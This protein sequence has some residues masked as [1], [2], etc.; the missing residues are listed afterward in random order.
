MPNTFYKTFWTGFLGEIRPIL[1]IEVTTAIN[2]DCVFG[3]TAQYEVDAPC[4]APIIDD[5]QFGMGTLGSVEFT[6]PGQNPCVSA[7]IEWS[8]DLISWFSQSLGC[9]SPSLVDIGSGNNY[10]SLY[11]RIQKTCQDGGL[12]SPYSELYEYIFPTPNPTPTNTPTSTNTP[13][14]TG[15]MVSPTPTPT[16]TTTPTETPT[17]TPTETPT[18]TPTTT[19]TPTNTPTPTSSPVPSTAF[20]MTIKTDNP[21]ATNT[22]TFRLPTRGT[23]NNFTIDWGDGVI[24]TFTGNTGNKDHIYSTA[25]TYQLSISATTLTGLGFGGTGDA[26]KVLSIDNWGNNTWSNMQ[27]SFEGCVNLRIYATDGPIFASGISLGAMFK[28]CTSLNDNIN[29]W[30]V[31]M[32]ARFAN[33]TVNTFNYGM[34]FGCTNFNQPLSGWNVSNCIDFAGMFGNCTN[35]N[36]DISNW[37]IRTGTTIRMDNMFNGCTSFNQPLNSW[38]LQDVT[39]INAI[40]ANTRDFNQPLSGWNVSK[41]TIFAAAFSGA[42]A[43]NQNINNWTTTAATNFTAFLNNA[44][45]YNQDLS[46]LEIN[47]IANGHN[48][49]TFASGTILSTENYS[50][51]L[52]SLAN[53]MNTLGK[54]T[55][56][57]IN[58]GNR[59]YNNTNYGGSPYSDGAAARAALVSSGWTITDGGQI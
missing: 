36:Q 54:P 59:T 33:L 9:I 29:H 16:N 34:F 49:T 46:G 53:Q 15:G 1:D 25:G 58:N 37:V 13:T 22:V 42:K 31:S 2:Q 19:T 10:G 56:C 24:E 14:P 7:V 3:G 45:S 50:R 21:G 18:N 28:N 8:R 48:F 27:A 44:E 11:F 38:N 6:L 57:T 4:L 40:L 20:K 26:Q 39:N 5:I 17:N 55:G 52:I 35:F 32:I 51:L 41:V 43:F 47:S 30:D 23:S 12:I